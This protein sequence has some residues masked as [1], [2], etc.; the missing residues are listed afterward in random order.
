MLC[1]VTGCLCGGGCVCLLLIK[2]IRQR[3]PTITPHNLYVH[4]NLCYNVLITCLCLWTDWY[5]LYKH[6][7]CNYFSSYQSYQTKK[8]KIILKVSVSH[9]E[10]TALYHTMPGSSV[11]YWE[12]SSVIAVKNNRQRRASITPEY[13]RVEEIIVHIFFCI[14]CNKFIITITLMLSCFMYSSNQVGK[15]CK[16]KHNTG[17]VIF[18]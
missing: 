10:H 2:T 11:L 1:I 8:Y 6:F 7:G 5:W 18:K 3:H 14:V 4:K 9:I 16:W 15:L 17:I 12:R 13:S